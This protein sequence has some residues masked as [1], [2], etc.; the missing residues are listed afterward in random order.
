MRV[1]DK[2]QADLDKLE[3]FVRVNKA[4]GVAS[5]AKSKKKVLEKL[6]DDTCVDALNNAAAHAAR[7]GPPGAQGRAAGSRSMGVGSLPQLKR[8]LE[9][10]RKRSLA[11]L[12][13]ALGDLIFV[14]EKLFRY[15]R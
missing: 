9:R 12:G 14:A 7:G 11:R 8:G 6:E 13:G 4:N 1:Y 10:A 3:T 15:T 5:S 2:Q